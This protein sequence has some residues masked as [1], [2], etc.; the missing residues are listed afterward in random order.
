[1]PCLHLLARVLLTQ[2]RTLL[3]SLA[4]RALVC[5]LPS[6]LHTKTFPMGLLPTR[7]PPACVF[8]EVSPLQ[9]QKLAFILWD[10]MKFLSI[11]VLLFLGP[12]PEAQRTEDLWSEK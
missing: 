11:P 6:P 10:F 7:Q 3:A 8:A 12:S 1:M 9:G 2:P 4:A 5:L